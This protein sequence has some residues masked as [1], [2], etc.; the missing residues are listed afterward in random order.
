MLATTDKSWVSIK[1]VWAS[2]SVNRYKYYYDK[3]CD[4]QVC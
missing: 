1:Q 2:E 4:L 3:M